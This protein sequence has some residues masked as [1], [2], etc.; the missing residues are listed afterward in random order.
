MFQIFPCASC[1][2]S[3]VAPG[4]GISLFGWWGDVAGQRGW[5]R[6]EGRL[7][8]PDRPVHIGQVFSI[9]A[10]QWWRVNMCWGSAMGQTP[11]GPWDAEMRE[12]GSR[13]PRGSWGRQAHLQI[14]PPPSSGCSMAAAHQAPWGGAASWTGRW[15]RP[16][17]P[18]DRARERLI[19]SGSTDGT[20]S[21]IFG[22]C[23][24]FS[25]VFVIS[26]LS[27]GILTAEGSLGPQ[28]L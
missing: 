1:R 26:I 17:S 23:V 18:C 10:L 14:K 19:P 2:G 8:R 3:P 25:F 24:L 20:R 6:A 9:W 21:G 11:V 15:P 12:M 7:G 27:E 16:G 22:F 4:A 13:F 5:E 28:M